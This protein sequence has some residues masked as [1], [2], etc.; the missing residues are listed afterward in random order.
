[1]I[2][3]AIRSRLPAR[4]DTDGYQ[5]AALRVAPS[6]E[7]RVTDELF[8]AGYRSYCPTGAKWV[9]WENGRRRRDKTVRVFPIFSRYVF[10]GLAPGQMASRYMVEKV[11]A[12]LG[13]KAGP[14]F[15]PPAAIKRLNELELEGAWDGTRS[16]RQK[17]PYRKGDAVSIL[18]GA[19]MGHRGTIDAVETEAKIFLLIDLFGRQTRI[20]AG[21][22][23]L[24][25]A[26]L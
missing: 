12:V 1:M 7:F 24:G 4:I 25:S 16:W 26:A 13:D 2:P 23:Q 20:S 8:G 15:V 11:E 22:C 14:I 3:L 5:W 21:A 6:A 18:D 19:F 9:F 17:S 10:C